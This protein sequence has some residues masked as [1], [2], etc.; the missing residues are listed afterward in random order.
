MN[1]HLLELKQLKQEKLK[2]QE[3]SLINSSRVENNNISN[4]FLNGEYQDTE[5]VKIEVNDFG[6][7]ESV[8]INISDI[9]NDDSHID[10][11]EYKK[12]IDKTMEEKKQNLQEMFEFNK[13]V[14]EADIKEKFEK[15]YQEIMEKEKSRLEE[16][17]KKRREELENSYKIRIDEYKTKI[18][19]QVEINIEE[20]NK[21]LKSELNKNL[22]NVEDEVDKLKIRL[23]EISSNDDT[24]Y[25]KKYEKEVK[26]IENNFESSLKNHQANL[27]LS[28]NE[29]RAKVRS[30]FG[31]KK[32][33][34]ENN[35]KK[36]IYNENEKNSISPENILKEKKQILLKTHEQRVESYKESLI[37]HFMSKLESEKEEAMRIFTLVLNNLKNNYDFLK[38]F[39]NE[40]KLLFST[41]LNII[42]TSNLINK[43]R[44]IYDNKNS[45]FKNLLD[46]N[47]FSMRKKL[48]EMENLKELS[49]FTNK[50]NVINKIS[51]L[52]TM[53]FYEHIYEYLHLDIA[54]D[55]EIIISCLDEIINKC[56]KIISGMD[57]DKKIQLNMLICNPNFNF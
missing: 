55:N 51:E 5:D 57:C 44:N 29:K 45:V 7:E 28:L 23:N 35:L 50:E 25:T 16:V 41:E 6:E 13:V 47:Y 21:K 39:Y 18:K 1:K 32:L 22:Q 34:Y 52:L 31:N 10:F 38:E 54:S 3:S 20:R 12:K 56:E 36:T 46:Q 19:T 9:D 8:N 48:R 24:D 26:K 37:S 40:Q 30:F 42:S 2:S 49:S 17:K 33:E 14:K 53:L 15:R 11:E 4:D 43:I 27:E